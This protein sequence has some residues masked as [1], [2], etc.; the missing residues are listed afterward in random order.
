MARAASSRSNRT[1]LIRQP[2][3]F[4]IVPT[5]QDEL[6]HTWEG[7]VT[8]AWKAFTFDGAYLWMGNKRLDPVHHQSHAHAGRV[9]LDRQPRPGRRV[10]AG[11][12]QRSSRPSTRRDRWPTSTG[13]GTESSFTGGRERIA[14]RISRSKRGTS[15]KA[16]GSRLGLIAVLLSWCGWIAFSRHVD[17]HA[18]ASEAGQGRR[19][20][21]Q[22]LLDLPRR[23]AAQEGRGQAR[24]QRRRQVARGGEGQ[25]RREEGRRSLAQGLPR[26][27]VVRAG[28][29][30]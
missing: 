5:A 30:R 3:D 6:G 18:R 14:D 16:N 19:S 2:Q 22:G 1:I 17:G 9:L 24:A 15:M 21:R 23:Q 7:G 12:V 20:R 27:E 10:A 26:Q 25:A 13:T 8:L 4:E 29:L 11:Q 28:R